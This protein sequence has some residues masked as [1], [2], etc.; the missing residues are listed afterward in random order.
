[1][2]ARILSLLFFLLLFLSLSIEVQSEDVSL[3]AIPPAGD[4][5]TIV[6]RKSSRWL[7]V[8]ARKMGSRK[9]MRSRLRGRVWET[10][11]SDEQRPLK[12]R[13]HQLECKLLLVRA[14]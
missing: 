13:S 8:Q 1:M 3:S 5:I 6:S 12:G 11:Q 2:P 14:I 10:G 4:G 7:I 9:S